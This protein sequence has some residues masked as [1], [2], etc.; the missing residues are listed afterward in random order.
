MAA[1]A[2]RPAP[3]PL[4]RRTSAG[5]HSLVSTGAPARRRPQPKKAFLRPALRRR[6]SGG[7]VHQRGRPRPRYPPA[8]RTRRPAP[9]RALT[10]VAGPQAAEGLVGQGAR[11]RSGT[12]GRRGLGQAPTQ[13]PRRVLLRAAGACAAPGARACRSLL[14]HRPPPAPRRAPCPCRTPAGP[15]RPADGG[16][17]PGREGWY[18]AGQPGRAPLRVSPTKR[19]RR[20]PSA[21]G[22]LAADSGPSLPAEAEG[23]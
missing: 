2:A 9:V 23:G 12:R 6:P 18:G 19:M 13:A 15:T 21:W 10:G 16:R 17:G 8:P 20:S 11:P 14:G 4:P 1:R 22:A 7:E 5:V 3:G